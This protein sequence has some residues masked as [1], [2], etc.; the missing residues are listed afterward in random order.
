MD[1]STAKASAVTDTTEREIVL[2]RV[3]DAPRESAHRELV[4]TRTF[5]A[6]RKVVFA[7]WTDPEQ[8]KRW[9]GPKDFTHPVCELDVR[10][11]VVIRIHM[12]G[13]DG[14]VYPMTG[15]NREIVEPERR[16]FS[17]SALEVLT[18]VTF[19]EN[20][21][22]TE[23]TMRASVTKTTREAAPYIKGMEQ[24][25]S[26]SLDRLAKQVAA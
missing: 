13:P 8:L 17:S 7:A 21:G 10:P 3:F 15:V 14:T 11:G 9:W 1:V 20:G 18:T 2:T 6:P 24:G 4:I 19:A 23:L 25:W 5:D 16:V 22:K 26:Q 12:R